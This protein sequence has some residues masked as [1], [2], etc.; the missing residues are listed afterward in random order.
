[1]TSRCSRSRRA[2][3]PRPTP[4]RSLSRS[5]TDRA[6]TA[7]ASWCRARPTA[8]R[9][10]PSTPKRSVRCCAGC[11]TCSVGDIAL[12]G[13]AREELRPEQVDDVVA[14]EGLELGLV[15]AAV[16]DELPRLG[17]HAEEV[18]YVP[19]ADVGSEHRAQL[20]AAG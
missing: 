16:R 17:E 12:D 6:P 11:A 7:S 4:F 19:V 14:R 18:G 15:D 13:C 3:I 5:S 20:D 9:S 10:C 8:S 2:T 1:P